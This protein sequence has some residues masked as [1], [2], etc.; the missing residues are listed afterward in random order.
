M[1][2]IHY[3]QIERKERVRESAMKEKESTPA[4]PNSRLTRM[5]IL[6]G[7]PYAEAALL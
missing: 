7:E 6:E 4:S 3:R 1:R 2:V 5:H